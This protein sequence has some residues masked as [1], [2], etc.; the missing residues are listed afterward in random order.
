MAARGSSNNK[1]RLS[2]S[3]KRKT[4]I[5][6]DSFQTFNNSI[7]VKKAA[8]MVP[9]QDTMNDSMGGELNGSKIFTSSDEG[10]DPGITQATVMPNCSAAEFQSRV[11]TSLNRANTDLSLSHPQHSSKGILRASFN[12]R[13]SDNNR[14]TDTLTESND[15]TIVSVKSSYIAVPSTVT[16]FLCSNK[17][18]HGKPRN[19][20]VPSSHQ[21][22]L[23]SFI[24]TSHVVD[25]NPIA[26]K[27]V[28]EGSHLSSTANMD[29]SPTITVPGPSS[30]SSSSSSVCTTMKHQQQISVNP[31]EKLSDRGHF[32][33]TDPCVTSNGMERDL[34][35]RRVC[36]T[37]KWIPG[38]EMDIYVCY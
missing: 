13:F 7:A 15:I 27:R 31:L 1:K 34:S 29:Q 4:W 35:R 12:D 14:L 18:S 6:S 30:S 20:K 28:P 37:Y 8:L 25:S 23:D 32:N 24:V 16:Q 19:S 33:T 36:P 5:C 11:E 3:R 38:K 26:I 22:T 9:D 17:L 10:S 2:L 21:T